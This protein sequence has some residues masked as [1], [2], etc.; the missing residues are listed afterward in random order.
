[1]PAGQVPILTFVN[2][3]R[4]GEIYPLSPSDSVIVGRS[5]EA[6][7]VLQD[8]SVSRKHARIYLA[9]GTLWLRDLGSRNGTLV[10]GQQVAR[11]RLASGDR[12][13]IGS[14]LLRL[15]WMAAK[16]ASRSSRRDDASARAMSG[17]LE[18]IP[19]ADVLQWLATSR[20]SGVLAVKGE[21]TGYLFLTD[22]RVTSAS[23]DGLNVASPEKALLR[24]MRWPQGRFEL[25]SAG[26]ADPEGPELQSSL[27]H[28]LMESARLQDELNHLAEVSGM[29]QDRVSLVFPPPAPWSSL[30][31]EGIDLLQVV[32]R[33]QFEELSW[34]DIAS[35]I[36][37]DEVAHAKTLVSLRKSGYVLRTY[38]SKVSKS[39][40]MFSSTNTVAAR[41]VN[42][43]W[44]VLLI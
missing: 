36:S 42:S 23:I 41:A 28:L 43:T 1:M 44:S 4:S 19:L 34:D 40:A 31:P 9:G 10:N 21:R 35:T 3:D 33:G 8:D 30:T 29:P 13:A 11:C 20:K 38:V 18:D 24:M 25:D 7:L 12:I 39:N 32:A 17:S 5:S 14:S 2:G 15:S 26:S 37:G 16:E 27:E 6:D 22:G